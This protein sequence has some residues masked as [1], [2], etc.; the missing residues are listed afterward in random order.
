MGI[1]LSW[2]WSGPVLDA[3][4]LVSDA[5][6]SYSEALGPA[7]SALLVVTAGP[8]A[9]VR[10]NLTGDSRSVVS[11]LECAEVPADVFLF[12]QREL[13]RDVL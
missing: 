12:S 1:V 9:Q 2:L 3:S 13:V 8:S 4:V 7:L 11:L 6:A 10:V 5:G